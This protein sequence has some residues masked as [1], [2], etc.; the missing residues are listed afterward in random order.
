[1][2]A[3]RERGHFD[4]ASSAHEDG[5]QTH[6]VRRT[7][8]GSPARGAA[9]R[10]D[11]SRL[12][13]QNSARGSD[14]LPQK[15]P[16]ADTVADVTPLACRAAAFRGG[17]RPPQCRLGSEPPTHRAASVAVLRRI[18]GTGHGAPPH[19]PLGAVAPRA[20]APRHG[21][22]ASAVSATV[23]PPR[24]WLGRC[25]PRHQCRRDGPAAAVARRGGVPGHRRRRDGPAAAA[26]TSRRGRQRIDWP[27]AFQSARNCS[28]PL[29]VSG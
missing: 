22:T 25:P 27:V 26:P 29:S 4:H 24:W 3:A 9:D 28:R 10:A 21:P 13:P 2:G 6:G 12:S 1:M 20:I 17:G 15:R 8:R 5:A 11:Q 16:M 19:R 7:P 23:P 18:G 14:T